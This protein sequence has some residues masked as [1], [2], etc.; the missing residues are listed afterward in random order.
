MGHF[1]FTLPESLT[2]SRLADSTGKILNTLSEIQNAPRGLMPNSWSASQTKV[3]QY[4]KSIIWA[5]FDN[6]NFLL[7]LLF[8]SQSSLQHVKCK[9]NHMIF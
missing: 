7:L 1:L 4:F 6:I 8:I 5:A 3:E 9:H 2:I